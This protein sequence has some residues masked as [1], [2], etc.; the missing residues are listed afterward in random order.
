MI[1]EETY[2]T[3]MQG[4]RAKQDKKGIESLYQADKSIKHLKGNLE[5]IDN[6]VNRMDNEELQESTGE[7][8]ERFGEEI[9]PGLRYIQKR[10]SEMDGWDPMRG[11]SEEKEKKIAVEVCWDIVTEIRQ[12][13]IDLDDT[14]FPKKTIKRINT[15]MKHRNDKSGI[16][17]IDLCDIVEEYAEDEHIEDLDKKARYTKNKFLEWSGQD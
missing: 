7:A 10:I 9:G 2:N 12:L 13:I 16:G 4:A 15:Y 8:F 14:M 6:R 5:A 17:V 11:V 3:W 1:D